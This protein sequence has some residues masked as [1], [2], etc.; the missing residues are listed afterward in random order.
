VPQNDDADALA[1]KSSDDVLELAPHY[2]GVEY[3]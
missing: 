3:R 1:S 2:Y